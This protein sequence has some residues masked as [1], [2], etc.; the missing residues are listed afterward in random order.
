MRIRPFLPVLL[1][2]AFPA[3]TTA[4][5]P[6]PIDVGVAPDGSVVVNQLPDIL[7][8]D[9]INR[10]LTSGLTT[11]FAFQAQIRGRDH[12]GGARI[13]IRFELW[14]EVFEVAAVG[15][16][17]SGD[18][19]QVKNIDE[20]VDWWNELRLTVLLPDESLERSTHRVDLQLDVVPFSQSEQDDTQRWFSRSFAASKTGASERVTD[21]AERRGDS[22][23][24]VLG[25]L[26]ATSIQRSAVSTHRWAIVVAPASP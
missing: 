16:D 3:M 2:V 4:Q 15:I 9:D 8:N 10:H 22:L 20:L 25:V 23:E 6:M 11:T 1:I 18:R 13:D 7:K 19:R 12:R 24:K 17:G 26:M 21:S 5:A 14:D